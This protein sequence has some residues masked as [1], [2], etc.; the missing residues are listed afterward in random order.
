MI[1]EMN[2]KRKNYAKAITYFKI[3]SSLYSKASYM[4]TLMLHTAI[5]M[6]NTGDKTHANSFYKAIVG[7]YPSSN[8]AKEAKKLLEKKIDFNFSA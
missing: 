5:S 3:S 7:K 4:P 6:D 1:G 2:F 8:E